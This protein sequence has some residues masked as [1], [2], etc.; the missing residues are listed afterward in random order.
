MTTSNSTNFS[1]TRNE[2]IADS[3][4]LLGVYSPGDTIDTK[5]YTFCSNI[6]NKMVKSWESQG[7]HLW[8][9]Q[10]GAIFLKANQ[11]FYSLKNTSVDISG[12]D[13]IFTHITSSSTGTSLTVDSTTGMTAADNI[14]IVLD[15]N[16][17]QWTTIVTIN[18]TTVIT[19]NTALTDTASIDNNV[20]V[21]TNRIDRPLHITSVRYRDSGGTER[22]IKIRGRDEYMAIPNKDAEGPANQ[23][24]FSPKVADALFYTWP[25]CD[26][27]NDCLT[28][29]YTR[30]IQDFDASTDTPDLPQE[31]LEPIT[32]NLSLRI[33]PA[34]GIS[35]QK[36]NP[37]ISVIALN[38]LMEMQLWDAEEGSTRIIPNYFYE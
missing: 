20:F 36:L 4:V 13:P 30:R 3:L 12:D 8:T 31:W 7:I 9:G 28:I 10:E 15:D 2:I 21:F 27:V 14:G 34:Y 33:A 25:V 19:I 5:D 11:H 1:Q 38:S 29:S 23:G 26:D 37:D 17:I 6:L 35:T 18:S 24:F 16:T 22:I 32:Y